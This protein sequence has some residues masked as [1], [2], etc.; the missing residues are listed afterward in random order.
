MFY[1]HYLIP[2]LPF[3]PSC[4][5]FL[6]S[7]ISFCLCF[8][9]LSFRI[10]LSSPSSHHLLYYLPH[11]FHFV[12]PSPS[13]PLLRSFH[14]PPLLVSSLISPLCFTSVLLACPFLS[15]AI[16]LS[17]MAAPSQ[18]GAFPGNRTSNTVPPQLNGPQLCFCHSRYMRRD[19]TE[20][21]PRKRQ[22]S[23]KTCLDP[24]K[25]CPWMTKINSEATFQNVMAIFLSATLLSGGWTKY[26]YKV[27]HHFTQDRF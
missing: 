7:H 6:N 26:M 2:F 20:K 18:L 15:P 4:W 12:I 13:R 8:Y 14:I 19:K 23:T 27:T 25:N 9:P 10:L 16:C 22:R 3:S 1:M 17:N 21:N 24:P 11:L 5:H